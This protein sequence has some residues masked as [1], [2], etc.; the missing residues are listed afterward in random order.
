M[1]LLKKFK[2]AD[3]P[4]KFALFECYQEEKKHSKL[5]FASVNPSFAV[6]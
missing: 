4:R 1:T 5:F 3:N 2:V 6:A